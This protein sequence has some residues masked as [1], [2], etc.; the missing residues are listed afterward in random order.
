MVSTVNEN[1]EQLYTKDKL[2]DVL[3]PKESDIVFFDQ[4]KIPLKKLFRP[5]FKCC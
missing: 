4:V 1:V 2:A 3:T 5:D